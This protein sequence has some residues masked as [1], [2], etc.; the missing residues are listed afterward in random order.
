MKEIIIFIGVGL[1]FAFA[2]IFGIVF[3][4]NE[5]SKYQCESYSKITAKETKYNNWDI[6]YIKTQEG[7][8]RWD[9]Y[10]YRS[11]SSEGLKK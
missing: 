2:A 11:I 8:Q 3:F 9:E 6:C 1:C 10:K 5:V 7:W 4:A